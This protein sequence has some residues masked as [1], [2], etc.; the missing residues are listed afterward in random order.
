[1]RGQINVALHILSLVSFIVAVAV[2]FAALFGPAWWVAKGTQYG[3]GLLRLCLPGEQCI[4]RKH[5]LQFKG[6]EEGMFEAE[7]SMFY[8]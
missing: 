2:N 6:S 8:F 7:C 3:P 1:M 5:L 4:F